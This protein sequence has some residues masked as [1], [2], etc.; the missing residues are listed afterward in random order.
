MCPIAMVIYLII[1]DSILI[2]TEKEAVRLPKYKPSDL[3]NDTFL[4]WNA[5]LSSAKWHLSSKK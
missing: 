1:C 4:S 3:E 2:K 5:H